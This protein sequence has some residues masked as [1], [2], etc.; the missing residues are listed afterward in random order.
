[1]RSGSAGMQ[2]CRYFQQVTCSL[3]TPICTHL[4]WVDTALFTHK[5]VS[6]RHTGNNAAA[7]SN[8][9]EHLPGIAVDVITVISKHL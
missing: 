9:F 5:R 1:M 8:T 7:Q 4:K 2:K 6:L 3:V